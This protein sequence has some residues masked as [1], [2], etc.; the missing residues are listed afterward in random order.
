MQEVRLALLD[1]FPVGL[2]VDAPW[3]SLLPE[4]VVG[5][6]FATQVLPGDPVRTKRTTGLGFEITSNGVEH[7]A[8][9]QSGEIVTETEGKGPVGTVGEQIV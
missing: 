1:S 2:L 5:A 6:R 9:T 8:I 3:V 4:E 7:V